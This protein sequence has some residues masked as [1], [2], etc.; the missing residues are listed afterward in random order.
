MLLE[1]ASVGAVT[2][3]ALG[4]P[5]SAFDAARRL[6]SLRSSEKPAQTFC[7]FKAFECDETFS[8]S[9]VGSFQNEGASL[10]ES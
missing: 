9:A 8:V 10:R 7:S 5:A 2:E 6:S 3:R 4:D 1:L